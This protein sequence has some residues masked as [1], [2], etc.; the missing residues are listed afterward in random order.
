MIHFSIFV[1][2][3]LLTWAEGSTEFFFYQNL[4][5]AVVGI[6]VFVINLSHFQVSWFTSEPLGQLYQSNLAQS[7]LGWRAFKFVSLYK[8]WAMS[9]LKRR[10]PVIR[11]YWIG[12]FLIFFK[13][14]LKKTIGQK[15]LNLWCGSILRY[16]RFKF[17]KVMIFRGEGGQKRGKKIIP[18]NSNVII[19]GIRCT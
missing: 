16:C 13:N 9:F 6:V 2:F 18:K 14:L 12:K 3:F 1:F 7:I 15:S 4:S 10:Y 17:V 11:N 5:I 19:F 8:W